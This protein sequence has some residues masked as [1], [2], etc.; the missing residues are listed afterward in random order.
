MGNDGST[1]SGTGVHEWTL[2]GNK[3][4]KRKTRTSNH[5]TK[6]KDIVCKAHSFAN[7]SV[8]VN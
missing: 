7:N 6:F 2:V 5:C 4:D 1:G 8:V 3:K